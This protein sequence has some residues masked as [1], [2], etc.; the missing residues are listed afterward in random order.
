MTQ[1]RVLL[2]LA[3]FV[4]WD[5]AILFPQHVAAADKSSGTRVSLNLS[6]LI[7]LSIQGLYM[8]LDEFALFYTVRKGE[9]LQPHKNTARKSNYDTLQCIFD[10]KKEK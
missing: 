8:R 6:P 2:L 1:S 7:V 5:M 3:H 4:L 9:T 10:K